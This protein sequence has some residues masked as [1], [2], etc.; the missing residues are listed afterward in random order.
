[1]LFYLRTLSAAHAATR[2]LVRDLV[3]FAQQQ[4]G[5]SLL[6][7]SSYVSSLHRCMDDLFVPYTDND[8]YVE[9]ETRHLQQIFYSSL[10][11]FHKI[12]QT[13]HL[14]KH[15][16]GGLFATFGA[17]VDSNGSKFTLNET[18]WMN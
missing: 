5:T 9:K 3:D 14:Q 10:S 7:S 15:Q 4:L 17:S 2:L 16:Y 11:A 13:R 18:L 1:M 8:R 12:Q 6:P